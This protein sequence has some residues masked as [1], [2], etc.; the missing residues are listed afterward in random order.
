[1][2]PDTGQAHVTALHPALTRGVGKCCNVWPGLRA[3][4]TACG[5]R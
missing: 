3:G 4:I 2:A 1:M 5:R